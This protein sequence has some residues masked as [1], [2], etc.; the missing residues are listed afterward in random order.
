MPIFD[1]GYQHWNGKLSGYAWRWLAVTRE[2]I[3]AH[4]RKRSTKY[5]VVSAWTPALLLV[6]F[7]AL[8]GLLEQKSELVQPFLPLLSMLPESIREGPKPYR[9]SVWTLAFHFFFNFEIS[10]SMILVLMV[11]PDLISQDLRFNAMPLYLSRPLRRRDYFLGKLGV[12]V[13]FLSA[14]TVFPALLAYLVGVAFSMDLSVVADTWH[15]LVGGVAFGLLAALTSGLV[16]L[17]FSSL[18]KNSRYVA[19]LWIG[20]WLLGD[21]ISW[22]LVSTVNRRDEE[23]TFMAVS[24]TANLARLKEALLDTAS[25]RDQLGE[26]FRTTIQQMQE[27]SEQQSARPARRGGLF[28]RRAAPPTPPPP[29]PD[30]GGPDLPEP[31]KGLVSPFPWTSSAAVLAGLCGLSLWILST[32]V[33]SLDRLR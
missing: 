2:G 26:A 20:L 25:A 19:M 28:R 11:G 21:M 12:I 7:L 5:L 16:M 27:L 15:L 29:P 4:L 18:S 23:K 24:Y 22:I 32:R 14:V 30:P 3:R 6:G 17:A 31:F 33:K 8:W 10:I 13:A 9:G 1:Q